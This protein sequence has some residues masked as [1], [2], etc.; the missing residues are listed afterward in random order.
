[1]SSRLLQLRS[2]HHSGARYSTVRRESMRSGLAEVFLFCAECMLNLLDLHFFYTGSFQIVVSNNIV[3]NCQ[4]GYAETRVDRG[5]TICRHLV[6]PRIG[7][8]DDS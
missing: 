1:M 8:S 7:I 5:E 3:C 4:G 2:N 6:G